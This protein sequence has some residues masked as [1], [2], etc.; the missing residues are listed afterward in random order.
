[1]VDQ[2]ISNLA[3][4]AGGVYYLSVSG[5]TGT[6]YDLVVTRNADFDVENNNTPDTAQNLLGAQVAGEQKV[7]GHTTG[8]AADLFSL[9]GSSFSGS[10]VLTGSKITLGIN[11]DGSF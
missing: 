5:S 11:D 3:V 6:D 10:L 7:L 8:G 9:H 2:Q 4:P 1:N